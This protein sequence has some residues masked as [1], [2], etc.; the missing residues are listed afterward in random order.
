VIALFPG[1]PGGEV[2]CYGSINC[3]VTGGPRC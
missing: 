2:K 1:R 3:A